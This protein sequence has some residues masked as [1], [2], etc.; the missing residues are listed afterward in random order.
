MSKNA[1]TFT[2]ESEA[3][4][5]HL[6]RPLHRLAYLDLVFADDDTDL[7]HDYLTI[8]FHTTFD[9]HSG[10]THT[11]HSR[12]DITLKATMSHLP[13][14][15]LDSAISDLT[16]TLLKDVLP[17]VRDE[18]FKGCWKMVKLPSDILH[19][20]HHISLSNIKTIGPVVCSASALPLPSSSRSDIDS[21]G[22]TPVLSAL[23]NNTN[24]LAVHPPAIRSKINTAP[25]NSNDTYEIGT[26]RLSSQHIA[27]HMV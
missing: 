11:L 19:D 18:W 15:K 22:S 23:K 27:F 3:L 25:E 5:G 17:Q 9:F 10:G 8:Q 7:V 20:N 4:D 1:S 13:S 16:T 12:Q 6:L 2:L 26:Q 21:M 14:L 24:R